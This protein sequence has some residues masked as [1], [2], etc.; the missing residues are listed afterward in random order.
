M[1]K[2]VKLVLA[3]C[4]IF[5]AIGVWISLSQGARREAVSFFHWLETMFWLGW[6]DVSH[7]F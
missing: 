7:K 6:A 5:V 3:V 2:L 4:V 1:R